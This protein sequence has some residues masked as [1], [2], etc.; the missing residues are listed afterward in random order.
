MSI[1]ITK[2]E[3][4]KIK[5]EFNVEKEIFNEALDEAFKKNSGKFK[6][7]GFRNGKVPRN[8]IEKAYGDGVLLDEAF[9]IIAE[10]EY[11]AAIIENK[12]DIVAQPEVSIEQIGKDKEL[13]FTIEKQAVY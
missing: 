9:N 7:P 12:L 11:M 10:K 2:L 8:V 6:M 3:G 13:I 4:S 5:L 1:K